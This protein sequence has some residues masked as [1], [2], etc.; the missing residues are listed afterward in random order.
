MMLSGWVSE[1]RA[2][3]QVTPAINPREATFTPSSKL[4]SQ[5]ELRKRGIKVLLRATKTKEGKNSVH[6]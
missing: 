5:G 2:S 6:L 1:L 4:A 3:C